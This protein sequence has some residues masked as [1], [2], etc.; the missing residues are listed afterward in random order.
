MNDGKTVSGNYQFGP[1]Q[2]PPSCTAKPCRRSI[3]GPILGEFGPKWILSWEVGLAQIGASS[4]P[5]HEKRG[6]IR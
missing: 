6:C 4:T 1:F 2:I 3:Y 5:G